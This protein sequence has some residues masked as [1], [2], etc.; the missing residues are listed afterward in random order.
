L[1][2][3]SLEQ[4][5]ESWRGLLS[6][7]ADALHSLLFVKGSWAALKAALAEFAAGNRHA[8]VRSALHL[9]LIKP[10][11]PPPPPP[12]PAELAPG[13]PASGASPAV[14][15]PAP[16]AVAAAP[17]SS[18]KGGRKAAAEV[19]AWCPGREMVCRELGLVPGAAPGPEA[20]LF[21]EQ[22]AIAVS[23]GKSIGCC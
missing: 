13:V 5:V 6:S 4:A 7:L 12:P 3:V 23:G 21:L 18:P 1:Q 16:P 8:I 15:L 20:E 10:L 22:A 19:P 11:P 17:A 14:G 2:V 9:Q